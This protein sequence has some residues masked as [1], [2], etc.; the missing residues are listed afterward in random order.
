MRKHDE[1]VE[2]VQARN[3]NRIER[4]SVAHGSRANGERACR[5]WYP[6][7]A[8]RITDHPPTSEVDLDRRAGDWITSGV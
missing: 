6:E 4:V 2:S 3:G 5:E 7:T 1:D 8:G